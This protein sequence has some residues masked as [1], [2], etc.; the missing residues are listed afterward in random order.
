MDPDIA[1]EMLGHCPM[2]ANSEYCELLQEI[3][4]ASLGVSD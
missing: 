2:L 3:G 1:H 4:L